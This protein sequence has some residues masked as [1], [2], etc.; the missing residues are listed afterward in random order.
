MEYVFK[1]RLS[2][3]M[4][5]VLLYKHLSGEFEFHRWP[6]VKKLIDGGYIEENCYGWLVVTEK[7]KAYCDNYHIDIKLP[8]KW[9]N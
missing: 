1:K 2:K 5:R 7:G 4:E 6:T 3:P 8:I 9:R